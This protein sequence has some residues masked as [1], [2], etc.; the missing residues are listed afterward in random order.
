MV[1]RS[2]KLLQAAN[3]IPCVLCRSI[4]T[5]VAAHS[6]AQEHGRGFAH[7]PPDYYVA[8]LCQRCHD[9]VDGRAGSLSKEEKREM[10]L[11][12]FVRTVAHWFEAGI[13]E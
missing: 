2:R 8:Y 11:R 4:G 5:T 13:V 1:F 3:G 12:A 10:W 6:N 9:E 7:K